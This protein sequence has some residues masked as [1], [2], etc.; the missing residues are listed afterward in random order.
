MLALVARLLA[1]SIAT[2]WHLAHLPLVAEAADFCAKGRLMD[3]P[4][5]ECHELSKQL[6]V[7]RAFNN[8][9]AIAVIMRQMAISHCPLGTYKSR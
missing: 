4:Q 2:L 5:K 6:S 3:Y 1:R 9:H 8:Q 7:Y